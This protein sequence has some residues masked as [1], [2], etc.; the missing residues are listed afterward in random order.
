[1]EIKKQAR[2]FGINMDNYNFNV[3]IDFSKISIPQRLDEM[4]KIA[5][6]RGGKCL[7]EV[8]IKS[9]IKLKYMCKDGH[10]FYQVPAD[11]KTH[12]CDKCANHQRRTIEEMH[13]LAEKKGGLCLSSKYINNK[14]PLLWQC[15]K[16]HQWESKPGNI[17]NNR[18]CR[19]CSN[20]AKRVILVSND[21]LDIAKQLYYLGKNL[22]T[23]NTELGLNQGTVQRWAKR[24]KWE[25]KH[26]IN[27]MLI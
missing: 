18:W 11:T 10:I 1:M 17:I 12:W 5:E 15:S 13:E 4:R 7:S 8:Y 20:E 21:K 22:V 9:D 23:I 16:G 25:S 24:F 6:S 27:K 3:Q 26:K 2:E 14:T 19:I